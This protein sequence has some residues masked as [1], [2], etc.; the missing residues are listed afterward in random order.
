MARGARAP[1]RYRELV[2]AEI[3]AMILH[4]Q[5]TGMSDPEIAH[6]LKSRGHEITVPN[7]RMRRFGMKDTANQR[8]LELAKNLPAFHI[9]RIN[10]LMAI[11]RDLWEVRRAATKPAD[12]IAADKAL[13]ELQTYLSTFAEATQYVVEEHNRIFGRGDGQ[14]G[15]VP[16][17]AV[18]P[19]R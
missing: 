6:Y 15:G 19:P 4:G 3:N 1:A 12:Q 11:R 16:T 18:E 5:I 8:M 9:E 2:D 10:E 14:A 13:M 17:V 7:V